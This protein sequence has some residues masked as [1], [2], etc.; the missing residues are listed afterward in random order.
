MVAYMQT[1]YLKA[2]EKNFGVKLQVRCTPHATAPAAQALMLVLIAS[3]C[4]H[5]A[6]RARLAASH[7]MHASHPCQ[8]RAHAAAA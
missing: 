1:P 8:R 7:P 2:S 4:M 5:A 3:A 6:C